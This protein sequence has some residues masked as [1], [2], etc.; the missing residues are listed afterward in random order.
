VLEYY[1]W[2]RSRLHF[3][4]QQR[5]IPLGGNT[6]FIRTDRLREVGGWDPECLAE[7]CEI[8]VR[9]S[10]R[11]A[12]VAVAYDPDLVTREETPGSVRELFKQRTRWNQGFLQVLR[13]GEWRRLPAVRQR[14][15]ARYTLAMPFLQ[16]FTGV[17]IPVSLATMILLDL[18]VLAALITFVP[19]VATLATLA[20]EA[21]G[22]GEFC[23]SYGHRA[24]LRDYLRLLLG[25]FPYHL[26]LGAAALR[27][28]LRE[29]R[30]ERGWEKTAHVGA[31]RTAGPARPAGG[32][33][34]HR[35]GHPW[36]WARHRSDPISCAP[37][38]DAGGQPRGN[39]RNGAASH[40]R[41]A[42]D[43]SRRERARIGRPPAWAVRAPL[44]A[45]G[46]H[47]P[48]AGPAH[49]GG[50]GARHRHGPGA[51]A[52]R[53]R[54]YLCRPGLGCA[55]LAH[56]WPLHLLV[57]PSAPG[58][59]AARR[60]DQPDRR[61][62]P[63]TT[64]VAAG[65]EFMLA[66]QLLSA[67]LLYGVARRLG[68]RRAAAAGAV[69]AFSLS[70]LALGMHRAVYLDNIATPL[71]LA[72]FLL[73]LSPTHRLAAHATGGLCLGAAVLV[74][75]TSLLLVPAVMWQYW[76]VSD[77]RT[78]RYSLILG[79]SL[80]CL[81]IAAYL[82]Y[83]TLR[84]ELLPGPGHVSLADAVWFQLT[85]RASSGNPLD[86]DSLSRRTLELWLGQD[87]WLL[88]A[89]TVVVPAGFAIR[90][91]RPVTAAFAILAAMALRPGYLPVPL[92]IGMLPFAS[93]LVAGIADSV[94]G[95]PGH[96]TLGR[97]EVEGERR[98]GRPGLGWVLVAAGLVMAVAVAAPQWWRR[99]RDL[100]TA[101]HDRP[102]R[103]AE[104]WIVENVPRDA[105]LLVDDGLWVDLVERGYRL[106]QVVWFYKL[107]TDRDVKGRYPD[108]W[109]EFDYLV[110]TAT[111]RSFPDNLPQARQ[112]QRRS[113]VVVTFGHG[114]QRVEIRK[115]QG[116]PL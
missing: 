96:R 46:Q 110:S 116:S 30:G 70:P 6:V 45:P 48:V 98:D 58:V 94:W 71:V 67:A 5:F 72:A 18:P 7:D 54:G 51:P 40:G 112:A 49:G 84:G 37:T 100:M 93:L 92:V 43:R 20:V 57:R 77:R 41:D 73:A 65:R 63:A 27:A 42:P 91:L 64:A 114:T 33:R 82:L 106:G 86:P 111:L 61:L 38:D 50:R 55:A 81:V 56:P 97:A 4:A 24:K 9:L 35:P 11:G 32:R 66:V 79:G 15:L 23:R 103:Q 107:D 90:R 74:K 14:L 113:K 25:T 12:K 60:L 16:A 87:P 26:L 8:G 10:S 62:R 75:E 76:Q 102:F 47:R 39:T 105:R 1:F 22:L 52:G 13:K 83:A 69:L 36:S 19:L 2:F 95:R 44:G 85:G 80:F 104:A 109:R 31:H 88:G 17:L 89:V 59:A 3:H 34:D 53:R 28:V 78:R 108:G 21:A 29:R 115:V 68:L 99:D 101:D